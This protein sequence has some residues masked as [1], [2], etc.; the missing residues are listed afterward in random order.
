[1]GWLGASGLPV[2]PNVVLVSPPVVRTALVREADL[3]ARLELYHAPVV[4][5]QLDGAEAQP[6]HG[7]PH[8]TLP[9]RF[10][11]RSCHIYCIDR[12]Y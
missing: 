6:L 10:D 7:S 12:H 9:V 4:D 1:M 8:G 11:I 5:L 3:L 2:G